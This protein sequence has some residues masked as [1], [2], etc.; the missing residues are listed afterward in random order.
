MLD[1]KKTD[2]KVLN[3]HIFYG[4]LIEMS[5]RRRKICPYTFPTDFPQLASLGKRV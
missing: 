3:F 2:L 1:F 5:E 4:I